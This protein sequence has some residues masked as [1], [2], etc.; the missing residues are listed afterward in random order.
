MKL[1]ISTLIISV[2]LVFVIIRST[3]IGFIR[4]ACELQNSPNSNTQKVIGHLRRTAREKLSPLSISGRQS[5]DSYEHFHY[6]SLRG[7]WILC[8]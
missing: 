8:R 7:P 3:L 6:I 2:F 4:S 5:G 1:T